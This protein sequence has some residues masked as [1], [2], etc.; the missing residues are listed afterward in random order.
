MKRV[1]ERSGGFVLLELLVVVG[2]LGLIAAVSFPYLLPA[3]AFSEIDGAARHLSN[4]GRSAMAHCALMR[5]RITV[6]VDMDNQEYWCVRWRTEDDFFDTEQETEDA[7]RT[8]EHGDEGLFGLGMFS[9]PEQL[10]DLDEEELQ[11]RAL[12]ME[13][14]FERFARMSL[15]ARARNARRESILDEIGPLF[16]EEFSLDEEEEYEEEIVLPLLH[17]TRVPENIEIETVT[18]G[19][20][21]YS[22][23]VVELDL[24]PL[25]L[26]QPV[27]FYLKNVNDRYFTV[28][29]DPIT[30]GTYL[31][32]G[33]ETPL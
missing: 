13:E 1:F 8:G 4:Y 7:G 27:V 14:T 10:L 19:G 30:G 33:K 18:V 24:S 12:Q 2:L 29:W 22:K 3:I 20:T 23:G 31:Y 16:D 26:V 25:G 28:E 17:R 21:D 9:N 15:Q 6:K 5:E 11:E 32:E